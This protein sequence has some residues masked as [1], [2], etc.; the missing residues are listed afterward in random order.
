MFITSKNFRRLKVVDNNLPRGRISS[1]ISDFGDE[2]SA[3]RIRHFREK[4]EQ[5]NGKSVALMICI[6]V[7]KIEN[8]H[9]RLF[10][11]C[12]ILIKK[13]TISTNIMKWYRDLALDNEYLIGIRGYRHMLHSIFSAFKSRKVWAQRAEFEQNLRVRAEFRAE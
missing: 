5:N 8:V 2:H 9:C 13:I 4:F 11:S 7:R 3:G 12:K 1:R 6:T 10:L